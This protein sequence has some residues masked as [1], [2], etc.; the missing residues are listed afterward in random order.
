[1]ILSGSAVVCVWPQHNNSS[2]FNA[3][4]NA[5]SAKFGRCFTPDVWWDGG[6]RNLPIIETIL[7]DN[8]RESTATGVCIN[9]KSDAHDRLL[10][11]G[12]CPPCRVSNMAV[13]TVFVLIN[14][15]NS[16]KRNQFYI[17]SIILPNM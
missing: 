11:M 7:N 14:C 13:K 6:N 12:K 10:L 1:M 8:L 5:F 9:I 2:D 4:L 17:Y 3:N 15:F 16:C